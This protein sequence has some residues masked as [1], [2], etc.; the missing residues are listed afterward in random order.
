MVPGH[1]VSAHSTTML[2]FF[3]RVTTVP[4]TVHIIRET[5]SSNVFDIIIIITLL[6]LSVFFNVPF[7]ITNLYGNIC[8]YHT[9]VIKTVSV[10]WAVGIDLIH[11]WSMVIDA[12]DFV[13]ITFLNPFFRAF[14]ASVILI[15]VTILVGSTSKNAEV[16]AFLPAIVVFFS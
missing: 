1:L 3:S 12:V 6:A 10:F 4:S 14:D 5:F 16:T 7:V 15:V 2:V 8:A 13:T 11:V 9:V